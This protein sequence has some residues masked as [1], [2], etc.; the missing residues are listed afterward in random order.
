MRA[1]HGTERPADTPTRTGNGPWQPADVRRAVRRAVTRRCLDRG[2]DYDETALADALLVASE[3]ASNAVL[4]G[5]GVTGFTVVADDAGIRISVSDRNDGLPVTMPRFDAEGRRRIG[6][7][8][9]S[10]V[11]RLSADVRIVPLP[12]GGK[13]ITALVA[14][15]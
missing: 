7:R 5:G 15:R 13:R 3:L 12:G 4:H 11:R 1:K 10:I 8:G 9:W 2:T 14:T 6:G